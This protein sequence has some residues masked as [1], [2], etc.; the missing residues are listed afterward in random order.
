MK[1]ILLTMM[2]LMEILQ[3]FKLYRRSKSQKPALR[4]QFDKDILALDEKINTAFYIYS[5]EI[6]EYFLIQAKNLYLV[7]SCYTYAF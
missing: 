5:G 7:F 4:D 3:T 6:L 1:N 2:F